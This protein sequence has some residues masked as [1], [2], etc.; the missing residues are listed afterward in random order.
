MLFRLIL[1]LKNQNS[2]SSAD[3]WY[4]S[5]AL[6]K[7]MSKSEKNCLYQFRADM[8]N[9]ADLGPSKMC[10]LLDIVRCGGAGVQ[11]GLCSTVV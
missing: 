2:E 5:T 6:I 1:G 8:Q 3:S 10:D 11:S 7:N 4:E 9:K